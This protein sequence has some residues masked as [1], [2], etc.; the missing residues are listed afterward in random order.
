VREAVITLPFF[1][2]EP[3]I[4]L[5]RIRHKVL[6]IRKSPRRERSD[7]KPQ[8]AVMHVDVN[9]VAGALGVR[10]IIDYDSMKISSMELSC[11]R[12]FA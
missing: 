1:H 8:L 2:S 9:G 6:M 11:G 7:G 4:S 10:R 12:R 5:A 3:Y